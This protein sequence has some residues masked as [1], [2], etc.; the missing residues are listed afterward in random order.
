M[1]RSSLSRRN[2]SIS[3][4][5]PVVEV[6]KVLSSSSW[7]T[8]ERLMKLRLSSTARKSSAEAVRMSA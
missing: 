5:K 3:P 4:A 8:S 6:R 7:S 1:K 2:D